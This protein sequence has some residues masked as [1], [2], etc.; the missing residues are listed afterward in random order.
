[1]K[2]SSYDLGYLTRIARVI[3]SAVFIVS[4]IA[5]LIYLSETMLY[6]MK[7]RFVTPLSALLLTCLIVST[8][9]T[10]G[11]SLIAERYP[12]KQLLVSSVI[13]L[14][15]TIY[16]IVT[17]LFPAIFTKTCPCFGASEAAAGL[18]P[19]PLIRN[20]ILLVMSIVCSLFYKK[21]IFDQT[22]HAL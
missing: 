11:F 15:F 3:L 19:L 4:G 8:E 18:D 10:V 22:R 14:V 1:M 16:H 7:F 20:I 21:R 12:A 13:M 17:M 9:L 6:F 2:L 5:K